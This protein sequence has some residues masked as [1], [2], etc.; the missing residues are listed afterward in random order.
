MFS[1]KHLKYFNKYLA[2]IQDNTLHGRSTFL[3][4]D[5]LYHNIVENLHLQDCRFRQAYKNYLQ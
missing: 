3:D 5:R 2:K 4:T 1:L